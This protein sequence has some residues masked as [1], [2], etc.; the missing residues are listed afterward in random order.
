MMQ[1]IKA[2][3]KSRIR[4]HKSRTLL[5]ATAIMLTAMLL[6]GLGTS[7]AGLLDVNKQQAKADGNVHAIFSGLNQRQIEM[8]GNH[9][10]VEAVEVSE[11]FATVEYGKMNGYLNVGKSIKEGIY[12]RLGNVIEG[13]EATLAD[14]ICGPKAFFERMDVEPVIGNKITVSF[15][16]HGKGTIQTREFTICGFVSQNDIAGLDI[17]DTRIIYSANVSEALAKEYLAEEEREYRAN[18]RVYGEEELKFDEIMAK[19]ETVAENIGYDKKNI[20]INSQYLYTMTDPGT[21]TIQI[22]GAIAFLVVFFAGMVIYSIYYVSVITDVQEIG[23][24]KALGASR[25]QI[26]KLFLTEGMRITVFAMPLGLFLGYLL[27]ALALPMIMRRLNEEIV[28][29][30]RIGQIHMFSLPVLLLAAAAVLFTVYLSL[31]KPMRMAARISPV[32]AMRYQESSQ[33]GKLRKGS[34]SVNVFR[35]CVANLWQNKKRTIVTML[36]MGLS[37]VLFICLAVVLGSMRAEDMARRNIRRDDFRLSMDFSQNDKEYPEKNLNLLQQQDLFGEALMTAIE[38]IDGVTGVKR[39]KQVLVG[40]EYPS[41]V[42]KDGSRVT[43]F[44]MDREQADEYQKVAARGTID[45]D[46]LVKECGVM[47]ATDIFFDEY[48]FSIGDMLPLTI[49]DGDRQIPFSV[50]IMGTVDIGV[51]GWFGLPEELWDSLD[52]EYDATTDLYIAAEK[53]KYEEVKSA[54]QEITDERDVFVLYSMDEEMRLGKMQ[55]NLV[56]YPMYMILIM[57][58]VISFMNLINTMIT[59]IITRKRELGVLQAIGLSDRQLIKMLAGEGMVFTIGALTLSLTLGNLLG[60]LAYEWAKENHFMSLQS[61]HYPFVETI[62]LSLVLILGQ[63]GVTWFL[64][65]RVRK[66]SLIDRIR[67]GE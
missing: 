9:M 38:E 67:S 47:V 61:Y 24:L 32:E 46:T 57:I 60:Y 31:L 1:T 42:F 64:A 51:T 10:D 44:C 14:E 63:L 39:D 23:K 3:A 56:K 54:L 21:E 52:L 2:L 19:I 16:P 22:V 62:L 4:Y 12:H 29:L 27:P 18:I 5:T 11:L 45:Y 25:K 41:E 36:T 6:M 66:E 65:G 55:V 50:K 43:M 33:K 49:Y 58:A 20:T 30:A 48:G 37:S 17:S 13:H 7:A 15:R 34:R 28:T 8:L 40:S 26:K 35:L 59:S 53:E